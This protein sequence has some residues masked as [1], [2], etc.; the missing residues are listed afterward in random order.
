MEKQHLKREK[1]M[2]KR[3]QSDKGVGGRAV[4]I[5]KKRGGKSHPQPKCRKKE[6]GACACQKIF[7]R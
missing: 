6:T 7:D 3:L 5:E 4:F 2:V 1:K